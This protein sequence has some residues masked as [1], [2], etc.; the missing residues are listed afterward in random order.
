M[1]HLQTRTCLFLVLAGVSSPQYQALLQYQAELARSLAS[2]PDKHLL[3]QFKLKGWLGPD[4]VCSGPELVGVALDKIALDASNYEV[5][6]GML[7]PNDAGRIKSALTGTHSL[8]IN[9][10]CLAFY[11]MW[12]IYCVTMHN[13]K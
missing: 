5:F 4:A 1:L 8:F 13:T 7:P 10:C 12:V 6:T 11:I 2:G 3:I 9:M